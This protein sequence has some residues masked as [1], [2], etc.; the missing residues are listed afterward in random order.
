MA[1]ELHLNI[2]GALKSAPFIFTFKTNLL[3]Y[4]HRIDRAIGA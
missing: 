2:N 4:D 1:L 3:T